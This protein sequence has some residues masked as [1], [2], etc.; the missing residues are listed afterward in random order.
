MSSLA[1]FDAQT[2]A[3]GLVALVH[4]PVRVPFGFHGYWVDEAL[5]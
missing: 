5:L 4:L 1:I 2:M 3:K